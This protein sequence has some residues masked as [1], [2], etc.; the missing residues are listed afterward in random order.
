VLHPS[1]VLTLKNRV[2]ASWTSAAMRSRPVAVVSCRYE[3]LVNA[4]E[5]TKNVTPIAGRGADAHCEA[6]EA[7]AK[8]TDPAANSAAVHHALRAIMRSCVTAGGAASP[9]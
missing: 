8:Q 3:A 4:I 2:P 5:P 6:N 1:N 7:T 9:G